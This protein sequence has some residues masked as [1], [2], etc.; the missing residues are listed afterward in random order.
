MLLRPILL[1]VPRYSEYI[2]DR[3]TEPSAFVSKCAFSLLK[4]TTD[5]QSGYFGSKKDAHINDSNIL[6]LFSDKGHLCQKT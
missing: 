5:R 6:N 1:H 4:Q 2:S 3:E